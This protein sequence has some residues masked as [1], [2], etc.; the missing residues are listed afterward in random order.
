MDRTTEAK[1]LER[2]RVRVSRAD[3][4]GYKTSCPFCGQE[5]G[6]RFVTREHADVPPNP[7]YAAGV[8]CPRCRETYEA[9]FT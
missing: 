5:V 2:R 1:D 8:R 3:F 9:L 6:P 4:L 7:P